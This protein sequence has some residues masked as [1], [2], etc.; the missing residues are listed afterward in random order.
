[1]PWS[2][3]VRPTDDLGAAGD[4]THSHRPVPYSIGADL[5]R[6]RLWLPLTLRDGEGFQSNDHVGQL[7]AGAHARPPRKMTDW[8]EKPTTD[9]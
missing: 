6:W 3:P 1:M 7:R 9:R 8:R 2:I 4:G 5:A